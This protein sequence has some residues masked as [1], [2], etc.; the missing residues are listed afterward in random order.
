MMQSARSNV[1]MAMHDGATITLGRLAISLQGSTHQQVV[2]ENAVRSHLPCNL[3]ANFVTKS[4]STVERHAC[5][6]A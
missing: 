6:C 2:K 5:R 1:K 3:M 4:T